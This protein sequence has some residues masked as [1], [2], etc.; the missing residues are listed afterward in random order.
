MLRTKVYVKSFIGYAVNLVH[1]QLNCTYWEILVFTGVIVKTEISIYVFVQTCEK[2]KQTHKD[3]SI[4]GFI[5]IT[6]P[7]TV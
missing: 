5:S 3:I 7:C 1:N 4:M 6:I 2:I